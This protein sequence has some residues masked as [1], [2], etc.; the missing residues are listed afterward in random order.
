MPPKAKAPRAAEPRTRPGAAA[1]AAAARAE[2]PAAVVGPRPGAKK[3]RGI[4]RVRVE[5]EE[6]S[7]K[8][9]F[10]DNMNNALLLARLFNCKVE[11][12][13]DDE[14]G[15][16][17]FPAD[18]D[19]RMV[20]DRSYTIVPSRRRK[21]LPD[22]EVDFVYEGGTIIV[23]S[24]VP[25]E[26]LMDDLVE[27]FRAG[28][29]GNNPKIE[30]LALDVRD[31]TLD[32]KDAERKLETL[33]IWLAK[34]LAETE[35]EGIERRLLRRKLRR[36]KAKLLR[37]IK[38][39]RGMLEELENFNYH[40]D[41]QFVRVESDPFSELNKWY[42]Y[43]AVEDELNAELVLHSINWR[44][45]K[46]AVGDG[47]DVPPFA[48]KDAFTDEDLIAR[49]VNMRSVIMQ[50]FMHG[51]GQYVAEDGTKVVG[52]FFRGKP[53]GK[54]TVTSAEGVFQG[55][56]DMGVRIGKGVMEYASGDVYEGWFDC[57]LAYRRSVPSQHSEFFVGE[58]HGKGVMEFADGSVYDGHWCEGRITG[59][60]K[61]T[62]PTGEIYEGQFVEGVLH[63]PGKH[64]WPNGD[65][66]Q[67]VYVYGELE[68]LGEERRVD[69][70][71]YT[72]WYWKGMKHLLG[73][74]K[75]LGTTYTGQF[76]LDSR[77][78]RGVL[79]YGKKNQLS[80]EGNWIAG[81]IGRGGCHGTK[82]TV[83]PFST[84]LR[85]VTQKSRTRFPKLVKLADREKKR[86]W[87]RLDA[88]DDIM[89]AYWMAKE[90]KEDKAYQQWDRR[91]ALVERALM[92][93]TQEAN[94]RRAAVVERMDRW[95]ER[96]LG[97]TLSQL[98]ADASMVEN[99]IRRRALA[100]LEK[101]LRE[102]K[103]MIDGITPE[104]RRKRE[105]D[106]ALARIKEEEKE[107]EK[108]LE[109]ERLAAL[110]ADAESEPDTEPDVEEYDIWGEA[111]D[112]E[113]IKELEK[114]LEERFRAGELDAGSRPP[115]AALSPPPSRGADA[116]R[117]SPPGS[118]SR[119]KFA[120][121]SVS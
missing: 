38:R 21:S 2:E 39:K 119:L 9:N 111:E 67:G 117:A 109:R 118:P 37:K 72:G 121:P 62:M 82:M 68:G 113:E 120:L 84:T 116:T 47:E 40:L 55:T 86:D 69:G 4:V 32:L 81:R 90:E 13:R 103:D 102:A 105:E 42:A 99:R 104:E 98:R 8:R 1:A 14:T 93:I 33:E 77:H 41:V 79:R 51:A 88:Y 20:A 83:S 43:F 34:D 46:L 35:E 80:F 59:A 75:S 58:P 48:S 26:V 65:T 108:E 25:R 17:I 78:G 53:H 91:M 76:Q 29:A 110:E 22:A 112:Q 30:E 19:S 100:E 27:W 45:V 95:V 6:D 24:N 107:L 50:R 16:Y 3:K 114:E 87:A 57:P 71:E 61:Y 89:D 12:L 66:E 49:E 18:I 106:A 5:G 92:R 56:Y 73:E 52:E 54:C 15:E 36:R 44:E 70:T 101:E 85:Y 115:T 23:L 63:G 28:I 10:V 7:E 60:G 31:H 94:E 64:T 96:Q 11:Y 74:E 97:L